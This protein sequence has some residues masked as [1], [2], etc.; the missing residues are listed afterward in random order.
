MSAIRR[1]SIF[2]Q[3]LYI[4]SAV[5]A[6][7]WFTRQRFLGGRCKWEPIYISSS[8][9]MLAGIQ[10]AFEDAPFVTFNVAQNNRSVPWLRYLGWF[11]TFPVLLVHLSNLPGE[12]HLNF[13]R[14]TRLMVCV[15]IMILALSSGSILD[16]GWSWL[17]FFEAL[18]AC[19]RIFYEAGSSASSPS[20]HS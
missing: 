9:A 14:T 7:C 13:L 8:A 15:Q 20:P 17:F 2:G 5:L 4:A 10:L 16:G 3:S 18:C 12:A 11:I 19:G 1:A 6:L